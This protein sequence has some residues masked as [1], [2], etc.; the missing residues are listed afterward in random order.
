MGAILVGRVAQAGVQT[1]FQILVSVFVNAAALLI[2]YVAHHHRL[3]N[4]A[5]LALATDVEREGGRGG[6]SCQE[7]FRRL[8]DQRHY[9]AGQ[10]RGSRILT[11]YDASRTELLL[12]ASY[13]GALSE[14]RES[15]S[16]KL[17]NSENGL[18]LDPDRRSLD[19]RI[20]IKCR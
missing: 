17:T 20:C 16:F 13:R 1:G 6:R 11:A 15:Y 12:A 8:T 2:L 10:K 19:C 7:D 18:G 3:C 4:V 5:L 14:A 9:C